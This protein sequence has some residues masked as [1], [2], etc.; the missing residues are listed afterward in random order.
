MNESEFYASFWQYYEAS[1]AGRPSLF[2]E[3]CAELVHYPEYNEP[4]DAAFFNN[5]YAVAM[6]FYGTEHGVLWTV[7]PYTH[8][9]LFDEQLDAEQ[10]KELN[11]MF[12]LRARHFTH[13]EDAFALFNSLCQAT[14]Y[15]KNRPARRK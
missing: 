8:D 6:F 7:V 1:S 13:A 9:M 3:N 10:W 4:D 15:A 2:L 5:I 12:R 14:V 11:E